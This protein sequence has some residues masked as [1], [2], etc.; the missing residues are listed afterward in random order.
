MKTNTNFQYLVQLF[1]KWDIL[2]TKVVERI[3][4][5]IVGCYFFFLIVLL[6]RYGGKI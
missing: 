3:N 1:L 6:M 4:T 5:H 2:Q